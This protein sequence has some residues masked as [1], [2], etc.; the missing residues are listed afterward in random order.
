[1][2][3]YKIGRNPDNDIVINDQSLRV[4]RYH[5]ILMVHENGRITIIDQSTNG[6][7]V[8]GEKIKSQYEITVSKSDRIVFA[9]K[10]QLDWSLIS[11]PIY[12]RPTTNTPEAKEPPFSGSPQKNSSEGNSRS[13][14]IGW[15]LIGLGIIGIFYNGISLTFEGICAVLAPIAGGIILLIR[16]KDKI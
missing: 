10:V 3:T 2:N 7:Y 4:S 14:L 12:H 5:A 16:A 6:T 11:K 1:M 9:H 15:I 8:N 13:K